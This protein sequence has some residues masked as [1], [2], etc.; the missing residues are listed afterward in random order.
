MDESNPVV[1]LCG[2]TWHIVEHSR[3]SPTAL[4]GKSINDRRTHSRLKTVGEKNLCS[5]CLRVRQKQGSD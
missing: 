4:C 1:L 3:Q 5:R 2:N